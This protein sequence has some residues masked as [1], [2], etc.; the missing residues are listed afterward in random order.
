MAHSGTHET[1]KFGERDSGNVLVVE[2]ESHGK[3]AKI[4][5]V[6]TGGL[7]WIT[8]SEEL[9]NRDDIIRVKENIESIQKPDR[10]PDTI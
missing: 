1:T 3:A 7:D 9:V 8:I 5:P 4:K 6:K 10:N 2:I